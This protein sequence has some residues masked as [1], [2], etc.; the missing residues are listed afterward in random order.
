[1]IRKLSSG[2][3][4]WLPIGLRVLHK[5]AAI[6][7]EEMDAAG[8]VELLM[9]AIQP[10]ELWQESQ[11]WEHYGAELLR[12]TDRHQTILSSHLRTRK[13]SQISPD[14]NYVAIVSYP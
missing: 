8:A 4:T 13:S 12:I 6:V 14:V 3:Y 10:A 11:R 2:L 7:R 5:V 9:P 1:M